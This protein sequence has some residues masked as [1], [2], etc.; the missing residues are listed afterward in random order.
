MAIALG[1]RLARIEPGSAFR[2][3]IQQRHAPPPGEI[4]AF[5]RR[6][7]E[8]VDALRHA[9]EDALRPLIA[10]VFASLHHRDDDARDRAA[11]QRIYASDLADL[12]FFAV[13]ASCRDFRHGRAG[14]GHWA[15]T[16]AEIRRVA[17][18]HMRQWQDEVAS[19][20]RVLDAEI[21]PD[22][23]IVDQSSRERMKAGFENLKA[24]I[25]VTNSV[26]KQS[27]EKSLSEVTPAE[28]EG[29]LERLMAQSSDPI[30][31]SAE[32]RHT[33][34]SDLDSFAREVLR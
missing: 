9:G 5:R 24:E 10:S 26:G 33:L 3:I 20:R 21:I 27:R 19:L 17:E 31:L 16:Q 25:A 28:A 12:P 1:R 7:T 2:G 4:E 30:T 14:D 8:L 22:R 23:E 18:K 6:R 13:E 11:M 15:P 32:A 34:F 29:N